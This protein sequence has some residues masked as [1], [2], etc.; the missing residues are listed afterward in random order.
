[1]RGKISGVD[2]DHVRIMLF[3]NTIF[4]NMRDVRI[5]LT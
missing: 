1:M 2:F 4:L 3:L 5:N